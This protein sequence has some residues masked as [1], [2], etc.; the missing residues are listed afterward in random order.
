MSDTATS[1]DLPPK[2]KALMIAALLTGAFMG[3]INE[4]LLATALPTIQEFFSISQGE[5]QWMTTAFLMT[6]GIMIPISAFLIDR[7]TTRGLFLTAIGLFG[8]G[9]AIAAIATSYPVLLLARVVQAAGSGIML[10]L[11]MT[12]LLAVIS[13]ERRGT[14][15]GMIGIVIAFGPAIGPTLSG[16]LLEHFSWRSLFITV[17]PIVAIT[18]TIAA[19]FL[20]NVTELRKPKID[21]LSI[22]L[23][24]V[25]FGSF[26][27][28]FSIASENGWGS[29]MVI[30]AIVIGTAV[31]GLFIWRQLILKTPMLE[32]R[33]FQFRIFTLAI[34]IT[35][36][37]LVSLI[38]AE[39][40]L[41]LFMQNVLQ[42][43][44]LESG[45]MLLP[46]AIVIGIMSPITGRLFDKFGAKWLALIGLSV[47]T[48]TTFMFTRLSLE[49]S[50]MYLTIIYAIRMFGLSFTLMPVMTSALNQLPPKWYAHGSAVANTLQQISAS[51]GTAILVTLVAMGT[52]SFVPDAN[53]SPELIGRLA[54]V[55]GFEWA[56]MGSTILAFAALILALFLHPPKKEKEI[57]RQIHGQE[58][59]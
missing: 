12:V 19:L 23:S 6:N 2:Q 4:T 45:L 18:I 17:L 59:E 5:V 53:V 36:T 28:G 55:T 32:F 51:I 39:T 56:F 8:T 7:F 48:V 57:V 13:V 20:R 35:M 22:I 44:P 25:G 31:I 41:P 49:T 26:L 34:V 47:V 33:V 50:F 1:W 30:T 58:T 54:Q 16:W 15:M 46:G 40:L 43:T 9:T 24:S 52:N 3:I 10:P 21:V 37:V 38:G 42:F 11:L 29:P 14:A 27:Y